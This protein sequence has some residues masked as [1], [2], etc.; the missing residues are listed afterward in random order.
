MK[1][2][3]DANERYPMYQPG[4]GKYGGYVVEA[5]E[6]TVKRWEDALAAF[7]QAQ[8]EMGAL[9]TAA[10]TEEMERKAREKVEKEA[11]EK[12]ERDRVA[13]ERRKADAAR[14][15]K[16]QAMW[17]RIA[18]DESVVYDSKGNPLGTVSQQAYGGVKLNP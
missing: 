4:D 10:E 3:V 6:A 11:A 13:K 16:E 18:A 17:D 15:A 9:Y 2:R 8:D 1:I 5:D 7:E 12:A 14:Q